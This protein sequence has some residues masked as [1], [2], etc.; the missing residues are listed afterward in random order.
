MFAITQEHLSFAGG[1]IGVITF[2]KVMVGSI[3]NKIEKNNKHLEDMIE[4]K[5]DKIV[6][7][8]HKRAFENWSNE[9]DRIIEEKISKIENSFK[10]DLQEI[11]ESLKEINQHMLNCRKN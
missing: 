3:D 2:V 8:E 6:Y 11:K 10:S 5:L 1:I 4:K 9:K 7:E